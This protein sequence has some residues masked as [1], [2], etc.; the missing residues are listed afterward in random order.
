MGS[1]HACVLESLGTEKGAGVGSY[2]RVHLPAHHFIHIDSEQ[3][4]V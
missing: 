4:S 2:S 3:C 1:A